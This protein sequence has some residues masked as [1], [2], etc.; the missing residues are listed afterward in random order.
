[1]GKKVNVGVRPEDFVESQGEDHIFRG[2]VNITEA[3]GEVTLLYF[4]KV[5][6][7]D[8]V[9]A[10][11]PGIHG[12]LRGRD[13]RL[14]ASPGKVHVFHEGQSLLYRDHPNRHISVKPH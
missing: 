2:K 5:G 12:D 11:L 9:I 4:E 10:K 1:M 6:D 14:T 13:V 3:L 8:A 7:A